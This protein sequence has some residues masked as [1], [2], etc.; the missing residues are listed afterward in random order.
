M[1]STSPE[2]PTPGARLRALLAQR[3]AVAVPGT[4]DALGAMLIGEAGFD[5]VYMSGYA[6]AASHG[7]PD[8][9]LITADQMVRRAA[10]IVDAVALPVIVDADAG[11]GGVANIA[12]V[13]RGYERAGVAAMHLEDQVSP[14]R[15][16]AMAGKA[17]VSDDEMA[18]RLRAALRAR[19]S[20]DFLIIGRTDAMTIGGIDEAVRRL[21]CME[22]VGVDAVMVPSLS[23]LEECRRVSEAVSVPVI[24]TVAETLRPLHGQAELAASGLGM[25]LYPITFIQGIVGLQRRMLATLRAQGS[26]AGFVDQMTPLPEISRLLGAESYAAL[27]ADVIGQRK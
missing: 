22:A 7:R 18:A 4:H 14:K 15:C 1:A 3:R 24:H 23:T 10:E 11:Y 2:S 20:P 25:A 19:R 13:V 6:V 27:E 9:G 16:G 26:T 8:I 17:L 12:D 21:Q 5:A